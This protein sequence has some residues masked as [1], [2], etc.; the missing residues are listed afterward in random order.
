MVTST[1]SNSSLSVRRNMGRN[2]SMETGGIKALFF[3]RH[4]C[5]DRCRYEGIVT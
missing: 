5:Y 2:V 4:H 3:N 1:K